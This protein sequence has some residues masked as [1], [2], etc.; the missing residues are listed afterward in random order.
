MHSEIQKGD[1]IISSNNRPLLNRP[2][3]KTQIQDV[4]ETLSGQLFVSR[5]V[6]FLRS[7]T[8]NNPSSS[9][10]Q[11]THV[12]LSTEDCEM[13]FDRSPSKLLSTTTTVEPSPPPQQQYPQQDD[14]ELEIAHR[15]EM[16][17]SLLQKDK[18]NRKRIAE[19][20]RQRILAA[21]RIRFEEEKAR[22]IEIEVS[23]RMDEERRK[24]AVEVQQAKTEAQHLEAELK[25]TTNNILRQQQEEQERQ[26]QRAVTEEIK[27]RVAEQTELE[28]KSLERQKQIAARE[29]VLVDKRAEQNARTL[30][31][32]TGIH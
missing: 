7:L 12:M 15:V 14:E 24:T 31:M 1:I 22:T 6:I 25:R 20:D 5:S 18:E 13:I 21:E 17:V 28:M 16:Q 29:L 2:I 3:I 8:T 23:K 27:K 9:S 26:T 19:Q 11:I 32:E 4:L 10:S 30:Q